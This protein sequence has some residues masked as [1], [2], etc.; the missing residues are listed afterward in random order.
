MSH[1]DDRKE[2]E[3]SKPRRPFGQR[4]SFMNKLAGVILVLCC[5]AI[6]FKHH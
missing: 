3:R 6:L 1:E 2:N 5:L 4:V